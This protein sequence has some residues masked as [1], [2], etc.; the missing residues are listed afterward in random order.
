MVLVSVVYLLYFIKKKCITKLRVLE[1]TSCCLKQSSKLWHIAICQF[2]TCY[3]NIFLN[4]VTQIAFQI[5]NIVSEL[6]LLFNIYL[7]LFNREKTKL[8]VFDK[9][10]ILGCIFHKIFFKLF[11]QRI[12][13]KISVC[14][15]DNIYVLVFQFPI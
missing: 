15:Q 10:G 3:F 5:Y 11:V 4:T 12:N 9:T 14:F 8:S 13:K 6:L 2:W 7:L 1:I